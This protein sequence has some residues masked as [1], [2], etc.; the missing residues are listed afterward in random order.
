[1][2]SCYEDLPRV[3][4]LIR[5]LERRGWSVWWNRTILPGRTFNQVIEEAL[6]AARCVRVVWSQHSV[7]SDWVK[8]EA[9]EGARRRILVPVLLDEVRIPLEFRR[10]Q[11]ARLLDWHDT[12]PH[13]EFEKVVRAVEETLETGAAASIQPPSGPASPEGDKPFGPAPRRGA[14]STAPCQGE[15]PARGTP[16]YD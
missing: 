12:G 13:P 5:A 9:A 8:T 10:I 6:D 1:M 2:L 14:G 4:V 15:R 7:N 11:A 3:G 16:P